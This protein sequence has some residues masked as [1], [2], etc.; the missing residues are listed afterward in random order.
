MPHDGRATGDILVRGPWGCAEYYRQPMRESFHGDWLITGDVG[1]IDGNECL[2]LSDRSKDLVKSGGEWISSVDLEN[3]ITAL[4]GIVQA[5]VVAQPHPRWEQ[6]PVAL[7]VLEDRSAVSAEQ[8][9]LHCSGRFAKWQLPDE[10]LFVDS[11]PTHLNR[12]DGQENG[13]RQPPRCRLQVAG[14]PIGGRGSHDPGVRPRVS[15]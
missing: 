3:H 12:Q 2:I 7:V 13:A 4:A 6:R 5:C 14:S 11:I 1:S 9:L 8:V 15:S 10:V